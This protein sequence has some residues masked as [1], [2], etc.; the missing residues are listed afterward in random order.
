MDTKVETSRPRK[1]NVS[2]SMTDAD[3]NLFVKDLVKREV[4]EVFRSLVVDEG[5]EVGKKQIDKS[6][7]K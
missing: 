3:F 2:K 5:L 1:D 4:K 7:N 6:R